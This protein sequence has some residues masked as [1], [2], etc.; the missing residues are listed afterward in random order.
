[1]LTSI[2]KIFIRVVIDRHCMWQTFILP[3]FMWHFLLIIMRA[4][5]SI[6]KN[7][8]ETF[9]PLSFTDLSYLSSFTLSSD[10]FSLTV[11]NHRPHSPTTAA[12]LSS[13][14]NLTTT[15]TLISNRHNHHL[16]GS[17]L[18]VTTNVAAT[19]TLISDHHRRRHHPQISPPQPLSLW[20][21]TTTIAISQIQLLLYIFSQFHFIFFFVCPSLVLLL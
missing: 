21:L 9:S 10:F 11:H 19:L 2:L 7:W 6:D 4:I 18:T 13:T 5:S 14:L 12:P 20:D 17:R 3:P 15:V 16:S 8:G 1:M